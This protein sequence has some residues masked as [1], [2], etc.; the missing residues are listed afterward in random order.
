MYMRKY[1]ETHKNQINESKRA[2]YLKAKLQRLMSA[3]PDDT[4]ADRRDR[5]YSED[6]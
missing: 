6:L 1:Y 3:Q 5:F 4:D 2:V